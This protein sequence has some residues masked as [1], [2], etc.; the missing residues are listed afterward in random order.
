M[1]FLNSSTFGS[2]PGGNGPSMYGAKRLEVVKLIIQSAGT[3]NNQYRRPISSHAD[4]K[5]LNMIEDTLDRSRNLDSLSLA[6][7]AFSLLKP[8]A[9]PERMMQIENGWQT[10][11][12][13]FFLHISVEDNM[14]IV[15]NHYY[16]GYTEHGDSSYGGHVDPE[17][18]FTI[19]SITSTK[20]ITQRTPTGVNVFQSPICNN[21]VLTGQPGGMGLLAAD[22]TYS[23][24]PESVVDD[25]LVEDLRSVSDTFYNTATIISTP[26]LSSR[27]NNA[28][29]DYMSSLLKGYKNTIIGGA[30]ES[31]EN[32]YEHL[33]TLVSSDTYN[34][35]HF[36]G[37]LMHRRVGAPMMTM[38]SHQFTLK[39]LGMLDPMLGSKTHIADNAQIVN[40]FHQAGQTSDWGQSTAEAQF[41][42]MIA[43]ALPT[44]MSSIHLSVIRF[45]AMNLTLNG[46][47]EILITDASGFNQQIDISPYLQMLS[48][49]LS[50]ELF[51]ALSY[52]NTMP[53]SV[54]VH[55]DT[56]GEAWI[57]VSLNQ[58]PAEVFVLP[59]FCDS[60][61][62]PMTT[63]NKHNLEHLSGD[64][65]SLFELVE[66]KT[67][68]ATQGASALFSQASIPQNYGLALPA[69]TP[70]NQPSGGFNT[71]FGALT[72]TPPFGNMNSGI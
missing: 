18:I 42:T 51:M 40:N 22:K 15:T 59:T 6:V 14:G 11:R 16:T 45:T 4:G 2:L 62:T 21:Q 48:Q 69:A 49:R 1:T 20:N 28:A 26:Q 17:M 34:S 7:P 37:W 56:L 47:I 43:Q 53:F 39:E 19:N 41:A 27:A 52:G 25:L 60:L 68:N 72:N 55:C 12:Y 64:F 23:L 57:T 13:R 33:K 67:L 70:F 24:R 66:Q 61:M 35:D 29:P 63:G 38:G 36:L 44:Y 5:L 9:T 8:D 65:R 10:R 32:N 54:E 46:Q 50:T 71:P 31:T 58:Q 30:G 3:Y